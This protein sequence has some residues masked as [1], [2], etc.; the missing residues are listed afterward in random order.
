[1]RVEL[2]GGVRLCLP[3]EVP[4]DGSVV[5][6]DKPQGWTSFDVVAKLRGLLRI[7]KIGHAGTLDPM[8]TGLLL[9][10]VG[11]ATKAQDALLGLPKAYEG[12]I[13]LGE[14]TPSQD[15]ET[16]VTERHSVEG[17][18]EEAIRAVAEGLTGPI[19]QIP[20]MYSA[21][22]V[23][24]KRLYKLARKGQE[25]ERAPRPVVVYRFDVEAVRLPDVDVFVA[26][27]K[28]TYVRTLAHDLG[29]ALG[30]GGHLVR[31][32]RTAI[33]DATLDH[34]WTLDTLAEACAAA[35]SDAR[36]DDAV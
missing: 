15:A 27:S 33:G 36:P 19:E 5:A 20:P 6:V 16:E 14:V 22:K 4:G 23:E 10:L 32:R 18:T 8:A 24:G 1:M 7:K 13:R 21:V 34:A 29:A 9:C 31:L 35:R 12:T 2:P 28:G 30:V 17:V 3:P 26:C 25:I 11:N